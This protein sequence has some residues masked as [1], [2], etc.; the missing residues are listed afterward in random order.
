V[1]SGKSGQSRDV[2][3]D[4]G[5]LSAHIRQGRFRVRTC[6]TKSGKCR[7]VFGDVGFVSVRVLRGRLSVATCL[8]ILFSVGTCTTWF[9]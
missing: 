6:S 3:G 5:L 9:S 7:D 8:R 1:C 2:F 4:V